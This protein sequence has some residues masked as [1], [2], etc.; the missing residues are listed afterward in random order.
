MLFVQ[1][2]SHI[3]ELLYLYDELVGEAGHTQGNKQRIIETWFWE[4][5]WE[6]DDE[7]AFEQFMQTSSIDE[8]MFQRRQQGEYCGSLQNL[9]FPM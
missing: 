7:P 2:A 4:S 5:V 9:P 6:D 1:D 3:Q 8:L